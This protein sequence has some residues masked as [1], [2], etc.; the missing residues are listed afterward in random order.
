MALTTTESKTADRITLGSF[1]VGTGAIALS[2]AADYN[3]KLLAV[4]TGACALGAASM[5]AR[6]LYDHA[7]QKIVEWKTLRMGSEANRASTAQE[8]AKVAERLQALESGIDNRIDVVSD[9]SSRRAQVAMGAWVQAATTLLGKA[10]LFDVAQSYADKDPA[11]LPANWLS[12]E[13]NLAHRVASY[14]RMLKADPLQW[15]SEGN[16]DLRVA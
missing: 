9:S 8:V 2:F 5:A 12:V 16:V 1:M 7:G 11:K 6:H 4:S 15:V 14:G 3:T 10:P 13:R